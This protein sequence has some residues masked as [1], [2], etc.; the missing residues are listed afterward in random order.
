MITDDCNV[1]RHTFK[2]ID[3]Q[4]C[5]YF[6]FFQATF[7]RQSQCMIWN[8]EAQEQAIC[9]EWTSFCVWV[10]LDVITETRTKWTILEGREEE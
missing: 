8:K 6:Y 9:L 2:N 3:F 10:R 1:E 7:N 5:L 4:N